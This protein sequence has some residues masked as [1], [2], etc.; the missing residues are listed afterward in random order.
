MVRHPPVV[1]VAAGEPIPGAEERIEDL[2]SPAEM[3]PQRGVML[4]VGESMIGSRH[5]AHGD[6]QVDGTLPLNGELWCSDE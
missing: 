5:P 1:A 2:H 6:D 3:L 4:K